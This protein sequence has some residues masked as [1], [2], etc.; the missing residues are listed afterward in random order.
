MHTLVPVVIGYNRMRGKAMGAMVDDQCGEDNLERLRTILRREA[1][2]A[3]VLPTDEWLSKAV[4]QL[5]KMYD[6]THSAWLSRQGET[7]GHVFEAIMPSG[8]ALLIGDRRVLLVLA[9]A[10]Q[11]VV[12]NTP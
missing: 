2:A 9:A 4:G 8:D 3:D 11:T 7:I 1:K 5:L 6:D 12:E 10:R